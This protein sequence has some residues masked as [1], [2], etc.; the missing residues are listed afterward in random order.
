MIL[1]TMKLLAER[2]LDAAS[3]LS[4]GGRP[5]GMNLPVPRGMI[6]SDAVI[7]ITHD[8]QVADAFDRSPDYA[9]Y[10]QNGPPLPAALQKNPKV[11][12]LAGAMMPSFD[13]CILQQYRITADRRLAATA[14]ALRLYAAE[15][16]GK[17]PATLDEL[18]PKYL[19]SVPNDPFAAGGKPLRFSLSDPG[20]PGIY[21]VGEDGIDDGG[22]RAPVNPRRNNS[23][24]WE[25][26]DAVLEMKPMRLLKT[27][28]EEKKADQEAEEAA[29]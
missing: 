26:R 13:R 15:H 6:Y 23:G 4:T 18:V 17:F 27:A 19:P 11:H 28:E 7:I 29:R 25:K 5:S 16:D 21:S 12:F 24:R 14:L 2:K 3:L 22:S 10:R 8:T 9:A 20:A 1:D